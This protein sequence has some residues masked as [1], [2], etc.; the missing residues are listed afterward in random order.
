[1]AFWR[2][3]VQRLGSFAF[4]SRHPDWKDGKPLPVH[5]GAQNLEDLWRFKHSG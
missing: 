5:A 1:M 4:A 2:F 3:R